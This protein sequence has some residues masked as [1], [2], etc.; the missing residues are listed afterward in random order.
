MRVASEAGVRVGLRVGVRDC[1]R[2]WRA[3][4]NVVR[5]V[6]FQRDSETQP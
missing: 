2:V 4:P 1:V 5:G 3:S 6:H